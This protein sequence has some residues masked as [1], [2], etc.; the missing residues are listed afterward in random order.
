MDILLDVDTL[1]CCS[2]FFDAFLRTP[3]RIS[4]V[5]FHENGS[6]LVGVALSK[7]AVTTDP[8]I[9]KNH[10][11]SLSFTSIHRLQKLLLL[12]YYARLLV[13][14]G[15]H[16][17]QFLSYDAVWFVV[18]VIVCRLLLWFVSTRKW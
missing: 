11:L 15:L 9:P 10:Q 6:L 12:L 13:F 8:R 4:L 1:V 2:S 17:G 7:P 16:G 3:S 14:L 5:N 18:M